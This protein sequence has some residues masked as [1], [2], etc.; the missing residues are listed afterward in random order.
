MDPFCS[1][2]PLPHFFLFPFLGFSST[3]EPGWL[4]PPPLLHVYSTGRFC[5]NL[6]AMAEFRPLLHRWLLHHAPSVSSALLSFSPHSFSLHLLLLVLGGHLCS[7][8]H[9]LTMGSVSSANSK[10]HMHV[11]SALPSQ[12]TWSNPLAVFSVAFPTTSVLAQ[13]PGVQPRSWTT[14]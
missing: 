8:R 13:L 10:F 6:Q 7:L 14:G 2:C 12:Q 5:V 4:P 9:T 11:P 3:G 1:L